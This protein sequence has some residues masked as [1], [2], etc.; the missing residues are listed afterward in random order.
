MRDISKQRNGKITRND[1]FSQLERKLTNDKISG[2][3]KNLADLGY[4]I[5]EDDCYTIMQ[6]L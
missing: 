6:N 2:S 5:E 3:I 4:V 1:L